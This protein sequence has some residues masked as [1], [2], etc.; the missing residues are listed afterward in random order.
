MQSI[1]EWSFCS[2][3]LSIFCI[4][5]T[6]DLKLYQ[7]WSV[8]LYRFRSQST[9]LVICVWLCA[10]SWY[11]FHRLRMETAYSALSRLWCGNRCRLNWKLDP[12]VC[13]KI[14]SSILSHSVIL[15]GSYQ[16]CWFCLH[17]VKNTPNNFPGSV[18]S[19][20]HSALPVM[21]FV[22]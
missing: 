11:L 20:Y 8:T 18:P 9:G 13:R 10:S 2:L 17:L 5:F 16:R 6:Q 12:N 14:S 21:G 3:S 4:E 7:P 15:N 1:T 19:D 22:G